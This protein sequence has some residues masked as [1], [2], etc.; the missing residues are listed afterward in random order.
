M[1]ASGSASVLT[2]WELDAARSAEGF[3][4]PPPIGLLDDWM[5]RNL[6]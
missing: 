2:T 5:Q 1:S 3:A 4:L 6:R